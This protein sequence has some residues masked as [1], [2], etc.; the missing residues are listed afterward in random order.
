LKVTVSKA[1]NP[2]SKEVL[3]FLKSCS[4]S[5]IAGVPS[6]GSIPGSSS[7][8]QAWK[9]RLAAR[10]AAATTHVKVFGSGLFMVN[11]PDLA[12]QFARIEEK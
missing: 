2:S 9:Q 11:P 6:N 10:K 1:S 12:L 8:A 4:L 5:S 3:A 7:C